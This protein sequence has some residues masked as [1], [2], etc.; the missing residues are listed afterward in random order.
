VRDGGQLREVSW[1]R[2]LEMAAGLAKHRGRVGA[3]IGGQATNEEGFLLG[4]LMREGLQSGDLDCRADGAPDVGVTRAVGAP[5]LQATVPDLE[6][7]HTV[8]VLGC[9]PLD[10][11]PILDLRIRKGVRRRGVKLAVATPRPSALD[12]NA[13]MVLRYPPGGEA[14]L[15]S[16]LSRGEGDLAA[17]LRDA[18]EDIVIVWGE[19][20]GQA[21]ALLP[22]VAQQ[23]GIVDRPG[24]G[25]LE[26]PVGSNGRGL[27]EAG[28]MPSDGGRAAAAIALA[29]AD[30]EITALYLFET[31]PLRDR[32]DRAL[33][34]RALQRAG[35]VVAHASVLT[36]GLA[37]H[38]DVVFPADTYAEKDGTVVH[39]D[40]RIQRL[41]TAIAHPGQ[42]RAGWW[43]L[44]EVAKRCGLDL[45]VLT[46]SMAFHQMVAAVPF[47]EGL[48]LEEIGGRGV[49]WPEREQASAFDVGDNSD[50]DRVIAHNL[51]PQNGA[52]R[53]GTY[54]PIWAAPE[55]EI[56]PSLHFTIARQQAELSPED[57]RRLNIRSDDLVEVSQNGSRLEATA[58]VRS[59][60][61]EGTVFLATGI[62]KDSANALT[63]PHVE[64]RK[65]S[66]TAPSPDGSAT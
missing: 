63:D 6:F 5:A 22:S 14:E 13:Q 42:V 62:A 36:E 28:V 32:A 33:W 30:S 64:V 8:L 11:A 2:A 23:L 19:R 57:A 65:L 37:E 54:K 15:L 41:R 66:Q 34:E 48:T 58:V 55:V 39:P 24:A 51:P 4:R 7:A 12:A 50:M 25:L 35:L 56:S 31:D 27:R 44:S 17:F 1:E 40:G 61:P 3:L 26:I 53:L 59:G 21:A 38:A 29:A 16:E 10:D 47:Y 49:R 46:A 60:I 20:I 52:L 43:V 45:G 18:G 9:E